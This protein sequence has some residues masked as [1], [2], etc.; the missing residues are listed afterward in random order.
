MGKRLS[1]MVLLGIREYREP[2]YK[3]V[4][5][6]MAFY[7]ML[8]LVP[9]FIVLSQLLG[10]MDIPMD[11]LQEVIERYAPERVAEFIESFL[12]YRSAAVSNI[13]FIIMAIW[14]AS[15]AEYC[16]M[17]LT[18]YTYSGG[19]DL[20]SFW[21]DRL[22]AMVT[23]VVTIVTMAVSAGIIVYGEVIFNKVLEV[24][25]LIRGGMV[26]TLWTLLRWPCAMVLYLFMVSLNYYILPRVRLKYRQ[27]LPGSI[28]GATG[29]L[30]VTIVYSAY[31]NHAVSYN[32]IYGSLA[33]IVAI[34]VWFYLISWALSL[35]VVFNKLWT[36][37]GRENLSGKRRIEI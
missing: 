16:L 30:V 1:Y 10:I 15:R 23:M 7:F 19:Q 17:R 14:S 8:S 20:G 22:R 34:M 3:G 11:A 12:E 25:P 31:A 5:A 29:M 9:T 36:V 6:Q 28:F 4:P 32:L 13:A 37:T 35:G 2:Y 18:N 27:I 33:S 21:R 24:I 26:D